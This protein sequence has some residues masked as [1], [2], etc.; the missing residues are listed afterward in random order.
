MC[1]GMV[2]L[3]MTGKLTLLPVGARAPY[4]L[5]YMWITCCATLFILQQMALTGRSSGVL[6]TVD[7]IFSFYVTL[8]FFKL[9]FPFFLLFHCVSYWFSLKWSK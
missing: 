1:A 7:H 9:A 5:R 6:L 4:E 3:Q 2:F 8:A